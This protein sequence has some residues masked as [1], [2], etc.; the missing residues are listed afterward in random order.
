MTRLTKIIVF[1]LIIVLSSLGSFL[2]GYHFYLIGNPLFPSRNA[3]LPT[4]LNEAVRLIDSRY[5]EPVSKDK[6]INGAV[7]GMVDSLNDPYAQ[8]LDKKRYSRF[9]TSLKGSYYGIGMYIQSKDKKVFITEVFN[10]SPAK[11]AGLKGGDQILEINGKL[12]A[13]MTADTA[14]ENIKGEEGTKVKLIIIRNKSKK[15][16]SITRAKIEVPNIISKMKADDIGYIMLHSFTDDVG[17]KM[18]KSISELKKQGAKKIILDLR[19]NPG[20]EL[21]EAVNVASLFIKEGLIVKT[22]NRDNEETVYNTSGNYTFEGRIVV[23]V[24]Q[25]SASASEIV[26]GAIK[27]HKRG[28]LIGEKTFGKGS[29]QEVIMLSNGGALIIPSQQWLTPSGNSISKQGIKPNIKVKGTSKQLK[30]AID[31]LSQK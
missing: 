24:N 25:G 18:S 9:R 4:V 11:K 16:Y 3:S 26:A 5:Y 7:E 10:N 23:L 19:G 30:K 13:K 21:K 22:K 15:T 14:S 12:T 31:F 29:I 2:L 1:I 8:Y 27:D 20:G 28:Q 17:K 6:L